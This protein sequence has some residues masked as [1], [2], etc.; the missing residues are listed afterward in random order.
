MIKKL[1]S[2][3]LVFL[4]IFALVA[5]DDKDNDDNDD[6]NGDNGSSV[7]TPGGDIGGNG[8]VDKTEGL[9]LSNA[10]IEQFEAAKSVKADLDFTLVAT[11]DTWYFDGSQNVN[12]ISYTDVK[13]DITITVAKNESGLFDAKIDATLSERYDKTAEYDVMPEQTILWFVDGVVYVYDE[14]LKAYMVTE[15]PVEELKTQIEGAIAVLTK[16]ITITDDEKNAVLKELGFAVVSTFDIK[17]NKGSISVDYKAAYDKL[18]AYIKALDLEKDTVR[19][20][21]DDALKLVDDELTSAKLVAELERVSNLTVNEALAEIDKYLTDNYDTTLQGIYDTIVNDARLLTLL[22]NIDTMMGDDE[23]FVPNEIIAQLK[24]IKIAEFVTEAGVADVKIIDVIMSFFSEPEEGVQPMAAA[25]EPTIFDQINA[26]L[27]MK[28]SELE[29]MIEMPI[30]TMAKSYIDCIKVNEYNSKIDLNFEGTFV[31]KSI[32]GS[33]NVDFAVDMPSQEVDGKT[34][35]IATD[36]SM[37]FKVYDIS[38]TAVEITAPD[39]EANT[40]IYD[41]FNETFSNEDAFVSISYGGTR[42]GEDEDWVYSGN[43]K[44]Y[45]YTEDGEICFEA[46]DIPMSVFESKTLV[47]PNECISLRIGGISFPISDADIVIELD[48]A[49][50]KIVSL[51]YPEIVEGE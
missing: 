32:E 40:F 50:K 22:N 37:T 46:Y 42:S 11:T 30:I 10:F 49:S 17:D 21:L 19:K 20:V 38:N 44:L 15:L 24:A 35:K 23:E 43:L 27:D 25:E 33:M 18:V 36:M 31:L 3:L 5:C 8:N 51:S 7:I 4:M 26:M 48:P 16:D 39:D 47:I 2:L 6:D 41:V 29:A 1:L 45:V 28:L 13:G 34:D 9:T 12:D 14:D